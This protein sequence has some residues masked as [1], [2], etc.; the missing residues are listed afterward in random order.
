ML[1]NLSLLIY[2]FVFGSFINVIIDRVPSG[3]FFSDKRSYCES[4]GKNLKW[5]DLVPLLSFILIKGKCRYCKTPIPKRLLL[6]EILTG[7]GFLSIYHFSDAGLS[8][9]LIFL[10]LIFSLYVAIFFI[11]AKHHIIP[12]SILI[13]LLCATLLMHIINGADLTQYII[14]GI[15]SFIFFL[16]LYLITKSKGIGFGDVK[17]SFVIGFMLGF[18]EAIVAFYAAFLTGAIISIILILIGKKK[19]KGSVIAFGPFLIIGVA[20]AALYTHE[21]ISLFF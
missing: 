8:F 2:G 15:I 19:A 7:I 20:I 21:I 13:T 14:T 18:P 3:K 6:V 9:T 12:D 4:C 17:F 16:I 10:L 5:Y 11:D 1:I